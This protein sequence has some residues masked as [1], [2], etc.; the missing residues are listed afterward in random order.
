VKLVVFDFDGTLAKTMGVD[1]ECFV[2]AFAEALD[3]RGFSTTW[4]DY[5]HV[6]DE[7]VTQQ[8][9]TERFGRRPLTHEIEKLVSHFVGLL[10]ARCEANSMDFKPVPGAAALVRQLRDG[11]EWGVAL[12]TG[13]WRRSVQFKI[14]RSGLP[15]TDIPSAFSEDG[16]SRE[17]TVLAAIDRAASHYR[18]HRFERIVSVGDAVWDVRTARKLGLPFLGIAD[19]P[20]ADE[21]RRNGASHVIEDYRNVE[22][23]LR[24]FD[25]ALQP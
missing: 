22:E 20:R 13:A 21:L 14:E 4:T 9:F 2:Q 1:S 25:E 8:I 3:V 18:Q 24:F 6:T 12:A 17:S 19:E 10:S 23:C 5:E 11:Q 7:G 15:I 16:P